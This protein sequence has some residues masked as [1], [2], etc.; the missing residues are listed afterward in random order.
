VAEI[1]ATTTTKEETM[2]TAVQTIH[3][4]CWS[5][6]HWLSHCEGFRVE[7]GG[8][9]LGLVEEVDPGEEALAVCAPA[10][11]GPA[12]TIPFADIRLI[13]AS[14]ERVVVKP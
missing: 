2:Q 4:G 9:R 3:S 5:D 7:A 13:D 6:K 14:A 12:L 10:Q 1:E 11:A 8:T